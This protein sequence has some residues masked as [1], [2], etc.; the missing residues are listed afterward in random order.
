ME[1]TKKEGNG[2]VEQDI[3]KSQTI[4][5]F[6]R[7]LRRLE[8]KYTNR[9]VMM[10]IFKRDI[11]NRVYPIDWLEYLVKYKLERAQEVKKAN[12][13]YFTKHPEQKRYFI[14][15]KRK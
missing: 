4:N 7:E 15:E 3:K 6:Y 8:E 5:A 9:S 2:G 12:K 1:N 11:M 13:A 14:Y 10:K